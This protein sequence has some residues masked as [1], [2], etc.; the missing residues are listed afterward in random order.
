MN[1]FDQF[2]AKK[3]KE[4]S[5]DEWIVTSSIP[6]PVYGSEVHIRFKDNG[7]I[8][9]QF[10]KDTIHQAENYLNMELPSLIVIPDVFLSPFIKHWLYKISGENPKPSEPTQDYNYLSPIDV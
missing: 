5:D 3:V 6:H 9:L 4:E 10:N 2:T 1:Y 7:E 8:A